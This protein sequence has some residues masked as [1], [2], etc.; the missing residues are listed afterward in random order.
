MVI[1]IKELLSWKDDEER[2]KKRRKEERDVLL[3][4]DANTDG[5]IGLNGA[6]EL[7]SIAIVGTKIQ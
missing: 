7:N 6:I 1:T 5:T 3:P 4:F 2:K